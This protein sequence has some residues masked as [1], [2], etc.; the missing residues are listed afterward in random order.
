[1]E[2]VAYGLVEVPIAN[3]PVEDVPVVMVIAKCRIELVAAGTGIAQGVVEAATSAI[4]GCGDEFPVGV[5]NPPEST[6]GF[7]L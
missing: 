1:V 2:L 3:T 6:G 5:L 7:A 4:L